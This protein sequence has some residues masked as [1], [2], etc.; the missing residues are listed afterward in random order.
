MKS[1]AVSL[2][3]ISILSTGVIL[4][5]SATAAIY[6]NI[7]TIARNVMPR[8]YQLESPAAVDENNYA[9]AAEDLVQKVGS[10]VDDKNQIY[11]GFTSYVM[12]TLALRQGDS[13]TEY[14]G[15]KAAVP[16]FLRVYDLDSYNARTHQDIRLNDVFIV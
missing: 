1:N 11:D 8:E 16:N 10:T 6:S 4:T 12:M 7:E 2:A 15:E 14:T 3:S 5:I 9:E 13:F